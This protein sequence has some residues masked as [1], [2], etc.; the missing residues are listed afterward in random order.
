M[1]AIALVVLAAALVALVALAIH[2]L[3]QKKHAILRNFPIL[4]HLRFWLEAVGPELR[5][6]IMTG[7]DDEKPFSRDQR[8]WIYSTAKKQDTYFG[9]G[10]DNDV[11]APNYL[12]VKESNFPLLAPADDPEAMTPCGKVLGGHRRREKAFRPASAINV[13]AMSFGALGGHATEAINRGAARAGCWQNTG[14]GAISK[15]H[16]H[17]GDLVFQIG[18]GY[19]G[20]R[21]ESGAFSL[22]NLIETIGDNPVKAIEIKISQGAKPCVGG[23]LPAAKVSAEIAAARGITPGVTCLSPPRHSTFSDVDSMLD[24]VELLADGTGLPVGIKS[25]VGQMEFWHDLAKAMSA[26]DR[27]VDFVSIDGGEGGTGAAPLVFSDHVAL[28]F[29]VAMSRVYRSFAQFELTDHVVFQ[30]SAKLGFPESALLAFGLGCDLVSVGREV[31]LAIGCIQS[32]RCHTGRCP[33]GVA[34]NSAWRQHGLDPAS[35][36]ERAG[37]YVVALRSEILQLS[38]AC[39]VTHP[40]LVTCEDFEVADGLLGTTDAYEVFNYRRGWG[41]PSSEDI[42]A[43]K[44]LMPAPE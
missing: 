39:G 31:M 2:D 4:G 21:D 36:G 32:Q 7:N 42:A 35:K 6:Y 33:T 22:E 18:T 30:G 34:T 9:F 29:K 26:D 10:T 16:H 3:T 23:I 14:E 28:P 27:G 17:G 25:A 13:S 5:Q 43:L 38:R 11:E 44:Q 8:R 1:L 24:F 15:Y 20:C 19:F 12:I 37:N 40:A 41:V